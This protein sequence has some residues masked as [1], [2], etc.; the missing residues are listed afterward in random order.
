MTGPFPSNR[1]ERSHDAE[2]WAALVHGAFGL[3]ADPLPPEPTHPKW[4]H[5]R[6]CGSECPL[7]ICRDCE[8]DISDWADWS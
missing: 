7:T 6:L 1:A 4:G 3:D 2:A 5:C 8:D